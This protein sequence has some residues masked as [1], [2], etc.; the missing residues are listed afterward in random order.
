MPRA[1]APLKVYRTPIG[2]H[3]A[4]VAAPSQK[5]AL[6]AWGS[7][8]NLFAR[9]AAELV[10]DPALTEEPLAAPGTIVKRLRGTT[11]EQIAALPPSKPRRK[12][13]RRAETTVAPP[14]KVAP[15]PK[16]PRP[17]RA[18]LDTAEQA[19]ADAGRRQADRLH[20]IEAREAALARER[21]AIEREQGREMAELMQRR[22][23]AQAAF[24]AAL[25]RWQETA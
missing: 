16:P 21:R 13:A 1:A 4:Y 15:K 10:T 11:A 7:D 20:D 3:D 6:A 2:F 5:A 14:R 12:G 17:S 22:E 9:G 19:L 18:E 8:A 25:K 24:D 23:A